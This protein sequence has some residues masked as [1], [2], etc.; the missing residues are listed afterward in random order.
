MPN[1]LAGNPQLSYNCAEAD[2]TMLASWRQHIAGQKNLL[3]IAH[4]VHALMAVPWL[5]VCNERALTAWRA[6]ALRC[7]L[8]ASTPWMKLKPNIH[9]IPSIADFQCCTTTY[10]KG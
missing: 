2:H 10:K 8:T 4:C 7:C 1:G 3:M 6:L 9:F 5:S